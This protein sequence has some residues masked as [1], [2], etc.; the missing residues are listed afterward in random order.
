MLNNPVVLAAAGELHDAAVA[1]NARALAAAA[2]IALAP[3]RPPACVGEPVVAN[4]GTGLAVALGPG[5]AVA[6]VAFTAQLVK[7]FV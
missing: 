5:A 7:P 1:A 4:C 3:R 2:H 6:A